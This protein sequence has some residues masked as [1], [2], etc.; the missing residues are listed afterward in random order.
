MSEWRLSHVVLAG[1]ASA[2]VAIVAAFAIVVNPTGLEPFYAALLAWPVV[3]G[4]FVAVDAEA[5]R[6]PRFAAVFCGSLV[7]LTLLFGAV[8]DYSLLDA[9][10]SG[11]PAGA[12]GFAVNPV[13]AV[14]VGGALVLSYYGVFQCGNGRKGGNDGRAV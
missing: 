2:I 14:L 3:V 1:V 9:A 8:V 7:G 5:R 4:A 10:L 6:L 11:V 12:V 13:M